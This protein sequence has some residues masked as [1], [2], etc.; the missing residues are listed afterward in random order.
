MIVA[1]DIDDCLCRRMGDKEHL[2]VEKY[3]HCI[4]IPHMIDIVNEVYDN[5]YEVVLYTARGMTQFKG[6]VDDVYKNLYQLTF[7]QMVEFGVKFH[8]LVMGKMHYDMLI[9]DKALNSDHIVEADDIL[10]RL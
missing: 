1:F 8:K 9:D 5:G 10:L 7:D 4:P 6:D 3:K 2:G